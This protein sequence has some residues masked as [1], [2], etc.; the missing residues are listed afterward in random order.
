M[1]WIED[2]Y[3]VVKNAISQDV[4]NLLST[5]FKMFR[6]NSQN[7]MDMYSH[8]DDL[9]EKSFCHYGFYAFEALLDTTIKDIVRR[10]TQLD[11]DPTYS[12]ARIYYNGAKMQKHTDRKACEISA[13]CCISTDGTPWPIGFLNRKF[14]EKYI[15]QQPGDIIIYRGEELIHWRD[16]Y[17]GH[18][19]VQA[20]L[21]YVD[22]NG[23]NAKYK[24]DLRE[25][26]GM[27]VV[28]YKDTK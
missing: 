27:A 7:K 13:T 23:K 2:G 4:C 1:S 6:D 24:F 5:Q 18:E 17:T 21:H 22:K 19:Q 11:V 25:Q 20:F 15:F 12:Y 14:E 26:L 16:E 3:V 10:E 8:R 28:K 9:V